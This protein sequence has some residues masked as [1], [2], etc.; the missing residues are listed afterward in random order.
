MGLNRSD[1]LD[2]EGY[3]A[4]KRLLTDDRLNIRPEWEAKLIRGDADGIR[5]AISQVDMLETKIVQAFE[6]Q[7]PDGFINLTQELKRWRDN[8]AARCL[9]AETAYNMPDDPESIIKE[10][11]E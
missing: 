11:K 7:W 5:K 8:L 2:V 3:D 9:L 6:H 4:I 1:M 10:N